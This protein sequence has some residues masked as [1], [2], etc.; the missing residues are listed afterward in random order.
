MSTIN[1]VWEP[2]RSGEYYEY[3]DSR[4][5]Y[6]HISSEATRL[7][8][9]ERLKYRKGVKSWGPTIIRAC[10]E[11]GLQSGDVL[12]PSHSL[13]IVHDLNSKALPFVATFWRFEYED[14]SRRGMAAR[15]TPIFC[16]ALGLEPTLHCAIDVLH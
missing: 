13:P 10:D 1:M 4:E 8:V 2:V 16:R 6:V 14:G 7:K 12:V 15:R 5:R 11:L 9:M 3:C